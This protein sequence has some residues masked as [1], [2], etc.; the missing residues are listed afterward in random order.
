MLLGSSVPWFY[1]DDLC[2]YYLS[3]CMWLVLYPSGLLWPRLDWWN[4]RINWIEDWR[5]KPKCSEKINPSNPFSLT[6]PT[7]MDLNGW[8]SVACQLHIRF[9][10]NILIH[11]HFFFIKPNM[12]IVIIQFILTCPISCTMIY[13]DEINQIEFLYAIEFFDS[14]RQPTFS[15]FNLCWMLSC[16]FQ[17]N[18]FS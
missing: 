16:G 15:I 12:Y 17:F 4:L 13:S 7:S 9:P 3:H 2:L 10:Q 18:S 8:S 5:G 1:R 11:F 6:N 14:F